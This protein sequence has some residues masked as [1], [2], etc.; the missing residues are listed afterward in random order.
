MHGAD[1]VSATGHAPLD[2][3]RNVVGAF[4][5]HL[6]Q[7]SDAYIRRINVE[8]S[9]QVVTGAASQ[10]RAARGDTADPHTDRYRDFIFPSG[11]PF[12][13]PADAP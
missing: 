2:H 3:L 8:S 13:N 11:L 1:N 12:T 6:N 9:V 5:Y 7:D 10:L 4:L